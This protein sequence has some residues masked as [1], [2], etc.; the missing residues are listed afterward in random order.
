MPVTGTL[1]RGPTDVLLLGT[2][3]DTEARGR[4][5]AELMLPAG[6]ITEALPGAGLSGRL[7]FELERGGLEGTDGR[8]VAE[9]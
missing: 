3:S 9:D 2:P 8:R 1:G 5:F 6:E 4:A 7:A